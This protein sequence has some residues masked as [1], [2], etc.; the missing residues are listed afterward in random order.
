LK[1]DL[2]KD[3][4]ISR[5]EIVTENGPCGGAVGEIDCKE[6]STRILKIVLRSELN[7]SI[8]RSRCPSKTDTECGILRYLCWS[9][10]ED[11]TAKD[12]GS[13]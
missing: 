12:A 1:V 4:S 5:H 11:K 7:E 13:K 9:K 3:D 8:W 6:P 10:R 2:I